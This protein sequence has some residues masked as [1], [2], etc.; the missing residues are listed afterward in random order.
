LVALEYLVV[1]RGRGGL[2]EYELLYRGEGDDGGAFVLGLIDVEEL[3][4]KARTYDSQVPGVNGILPGGF[5]GGSGAHPAPFRDGGRVLS[6]NKG[7]GSR[8]GNAPI[9]EKAYRGKAAPSHRNG[10]EA[11]HPLVAPLAAVGGV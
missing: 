7:K 3:R 1:H 8:D 11:L 6:P 2:F 10:K 4:Q 9:P 5:R